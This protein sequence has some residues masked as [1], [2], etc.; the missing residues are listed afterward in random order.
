[1]LKQIEPQ[2]PLVKIPNLYPVVREVPADLDTPVSIYLKL[3]GDG[4]SF[5]LE[6]V[7]GGEQVARYSFIGT[8]LHTAYVLRGRVM[9]MHAEE[10]IT[11]YHLEDEDDP[12]DLLREKLSGYAQ[13]QIPGMPRFSGGLVATWDMKPP[14]FSSRAYRPVWH[15]ANQ[16]RERRMQSFCWQIPWW[17]ST[18]RSAV[19]C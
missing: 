18:M 1:M 8:Q 10:G 19:Y 16:T 7:T 4:P 9:E 12:L 13:A 15:P 14:H 6:S 2:L 11:Q 5:L 3:A 17:H